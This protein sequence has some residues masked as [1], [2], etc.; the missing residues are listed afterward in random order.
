MSYRCQS[1]N[2]TFGLK[3]S[4]ERHLLSNSHNKR[5]DANL[6]V[7]ACKCGKS[8]LYRQ[9]LY[10]HRLECVGPPLPI[11]EE[12]QEDTNRKEHKEMKT[13][14]AM[15][16]ENKSGNKHV[17]MEKEQKHTSRQII[18]PEKEYK[19]MK[20]QIEMLLEDKHTSRQII[21]T[22]K[23]YKEMKKKIEILE[24][25]HTP[26]QPQSQTLILLEKENKE[27]KTQIERLLASHQP[28]PQP[29]Q[30]QGKRKKINKDLRKQ[31]TEKQQNTCG[32]CKSAL[33]PYF[34]LDHIIGLQF[35]GTNEESNLMALCRECHGIKSIT[36]NQCRKQI[37]DAITTILREKRTKFYSTFPHYS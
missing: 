9:S 18:L 13:Q 32:E 1:C 11:K 15:L 28:Q 7:Y 26:Q 27:M 2:K 12:E 4:Y 10:N 19:K 29:Q 23:E 16:N 8:Y 20:T 36:E 35:G 17:S 5:K 33:S 30:Q 24:E 34:E 25:K 31:I 22:E 21:L 14:I 6:K 37:Q 3:Q